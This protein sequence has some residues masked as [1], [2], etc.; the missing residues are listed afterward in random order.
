MS[1]QFSIWTG[2]QAADPENGRRAA[3]ID[4]L[5]APAPLPRCALVTFWWGRTRLEFAVVAC[6]IR[7]TSWGAERMTWLH[8]KGT[9]VTANV[10]EGAVGTMAIL[11]P[12]HYVTGVRP[13][14]GFTITERHA[15]GTSGLFPPSRPAPPHAMPL[16]EI[17]RALAGLAGAPADSRGFSIAYPLFA[18]RRL[19]GEYV[20]FGSREGAEFG[21]LVFTT[22]AGAVE[23]LRSAQSRP[24]R[25]RELQGGIQIERFDRLAVFRRFLRSIR[26]SGTF[27]LFDPVAG[28]DDDHLYVDRPY[29]AAVVVEQ[30]LPQIAWGVSYPVFVLRSAT[31]G[32]SLVSTEGHGE[33]GTRVTLLPVFT[34][35]DLADR[36]LALAPHG[37]TVMPVPDSATFARLVGELPQEAGVTF[38]PEPARRAKVALL[39][40]DLLENLEDMEL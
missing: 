37:T 8:C 4:P 31:P 39:R 32:L 22:E 25:L 1:Q 6:T 2:G 28:L 17:E 33:D 19:D 9:Q 5:P 36:A 16:P 34:D 7:A 3:A 40:D 11:V 21:V 23:F 10:P 15:G 35:A 18:L 20:G 38:D 13:G 26:D 24:Q 29:P 30:F 14:P 12:A 27:V